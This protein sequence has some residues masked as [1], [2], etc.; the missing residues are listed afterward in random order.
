MEI[1]LQYFEASMYLIITME[2]LTTIES[3][4]KLQNISQCIQ[5]FGFLEFIFTS[6]IF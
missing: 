6:F 3:H 2:V 5:L 4:I 1:L